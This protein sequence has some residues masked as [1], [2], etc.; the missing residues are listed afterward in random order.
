M[1]SFSLLFLEKKRSFDEGADNTGIERS[2]ANTTI[3]GVVK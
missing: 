3:K 1:E 2:I